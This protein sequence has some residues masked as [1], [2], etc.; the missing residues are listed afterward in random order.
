M[1]SETPKLDLFS[2]S[3]IANML[4]SQTVMFGVLVEEL[5]QK[6]HIDRHR[7][8][9]KM[10]EAMALYG[11]AFGRDVKTAPMRHLISMLENDTLRCL[12]TPGTE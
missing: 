6:G 2:P 10:Y 1:K 4:G 11:D 8:I 5:A 7:F 9:A 3:D 12:S